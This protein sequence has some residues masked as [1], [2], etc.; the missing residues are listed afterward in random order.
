MS[1]VRT[2]STSI[3]SG[4]DSERVGEHEDGGEDA[5]NSL[6]VLKERL[7]KF[8]EGAMVVRGSKARG[9]SRKTRR[10]L[11]YARHGFAKLVCHWGK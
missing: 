8:S 7:L 6:E 1:S 10:P 5:K 11:L 2:V 3:A 9:D 4:D